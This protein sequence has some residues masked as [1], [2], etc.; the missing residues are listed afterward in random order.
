MPEMPMLVHG[1]LKAN[2]DVLHSQLPETA[3]GTSSG[4][5]S[6]QHGNYRS[7]D[8]KSLRYVIAGAA[9]L[10]TAGLWSGATLLATGGQPSLLSYLAA[11]SGFLLILRGLF[12]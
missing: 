10:I 11:I 8:D 1:F 2:K 3:G 6:A 12:R 5:L 7:P 4:R 9:I